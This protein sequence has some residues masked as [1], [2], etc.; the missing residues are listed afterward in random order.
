MPATAQVITGSG[1]IVSFTEIAR[2]TRLDTSYISRIFSGERR[3]SLRVASRIATYLGM[4]LD[5][6]YA[7]WSSRDLPDVTS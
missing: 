7:R 5:D 2:A 6:F 3:P 4:S 1:E